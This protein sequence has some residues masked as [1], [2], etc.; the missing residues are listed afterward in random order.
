MQVSYNGYYGSFPNFS[1]EFDS[2][3]LHQFDYIDCT[4][5]DYAA[6]DAFARQLSQND[7]RGDEADRGTAL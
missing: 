1:S 5:V 2:L 4:E 6:S 7:S 3:H